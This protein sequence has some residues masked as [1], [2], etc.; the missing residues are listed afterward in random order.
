MKH[1]NRSEPNIQ[2]KYSIPQMN[3]VD[4]LHLKAFHETTEQFLLTIQKH[5]IRSY[6]QQLEQQKEHI[7]CIRECNDFD[8]NALTNAIIHDAE[9]K[10]AFKNAV[11]F[12]KTRLDM[13]LESFI[14]EDSKT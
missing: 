13:I 11:L 5:M 2:V 10:D 8:V 4:N 14:P 9:Q 6:K 12:M 3:S 1:C 7:D